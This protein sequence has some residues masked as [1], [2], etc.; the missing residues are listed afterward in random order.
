MV[1]RLAFGLTLF[2][3][4]AFAP[5][6]ARADETVTSKDADACQPDIH[7]L[8]DAAFP[9]EK[10]VANCLVAKRAQL[11]NACAEVLARPRSPEDDDDE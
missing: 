2:V 4:A 8:C 7:R 6:F 1:Q 11:S 10:L 5:E 3:L 9:D